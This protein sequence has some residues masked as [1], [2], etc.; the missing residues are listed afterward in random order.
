MIGVLYMANWLTGTESSDL[1]RQEL[2]DPLHSKLLIGMIFCI[3][4]IN[5]FLFSITAISNHNRI[6]LFTDLTCIILGSA[7]LALVLTGKMSPLVARY[8]SLFLLGG[9]FLFLTASGGREATGYIWSF[10]YPL[11]ALFLLG[12]KQGTIATLLFFASVLLLFLLPPGYLPMM[13]VYSTTLK[14][15]FVDSFIALSIIALLIEH[16][17][18]NA[19]EKLRAQNM[20]LLR[21]LDEVQNS[22]RRV[23]TL[24]SSALTLINLSNSNKIYEYVGTN[25]LTLVPQS[26]ILVFE[27]QDLTMTIKG[28][29]GID[30]SLLSR[31]T[32]LLGYNPVGKSFTTNFSMH[33]ELCEGKLIHHEKG[34]TSLASPTVP[35]KITTTI[36][37]L[38]GISGSYSIGFCYNQHL[39]G[40]I[41]IFTRKGNDIINPEFIE[42]YII[43]ASAILQRQYVEE[44]LVDQNRFLESLIAALPNPVLYTDKQSR[45]LGCNSSFETMMGIR[46]ELL[47]GK[48]NESIWPE[49]LRPIFEEM[50]QRLINEGTSQRTEVVLPYANGCSGNFIIKQSYFQRSNGSMGGTILSFLDISDQV[51]ARDAAETA[52]RL[53]SQFLANISHEIRTP[54]NGI[55]GMSDLLLLTRLNEEQRSYTGSVQ[56]CANALLTL[57]N[58]ILDL[59]KIEAQKTKLEQIDFALADIIA[60][61]SSINSYQLSQKSLSFSVNV[62]PEIP[63]ILR[64][65]PGRLRQILLNLVGNA[66]KF[67][68]SGSVTLTVEVESSDEHHLALTFTI[69]DTGIGIPETMIEQ[70]FEPFSQVD[71]SETRRYG[72]TGLGLSI[73]RRLSRMMGGDI[74]VE[75]TP[76]KGSIF[77]VRLQFDQVVGSTGYSAAAENRQNPS[78]PKPYRLRRILLMEDNPMNR[79]VVTSMLEKIGHSVVTA[80]NGRIGIEALKKAEFDIVLLD[81]HMPVLDG[82]QTAAAIR[83]GEA[84]SA[85]KEIPLIALT[86]TALQQDLDKCATSGINGYLIKPF[87]FNDLQRCIDNY[88]AAPLHLPITVNMSIP[89]P[90]FDLDAALNFMDHDEEIV[91]Q[92]IEVFIEQAPVYLEQIS[93]KAQ[94]G[95][96]TAVNQTAHTLKSSALT[97]GATALGMTAARLEVISSL[98]RDTRSLLD[99]LQDDYK[100]FLSQVVE[101]FPDKAAS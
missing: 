33:E 95:S 48:T 58:D 35:E 86:A 96:L 47:T 80:E 94:D 49:E 39:F 12:I 51:A 23:S 76:G 22:E 17:R 55:I 20:V 42:T 24:N 30:Q 70:L 5:G 77:S 1:S 52:N 43:Q 90:Y 63:S 10:S 92:A 67:T 25:L 26:I 2:P 11:C 28:L 62:S 54:L 100:N 13:P 82:Y 75:S 74:A 97:V 83:S 6:D 7:N 8:T 66:I 21:A 37:R 36:A 40:G 38:T 69:S 18:S 4:I 61:V 14:I 68:E 73:S 72:G 27:S 32:S 29:F 85:T 93:R 45:I 84:G 60:G 99:Q 88:A 89:P 46:R 59:S 16:S 101:H 87:H 57:L 65:D 34:F 79:M 78:L 81:L 56:A 50:E 98:D 91:C 9:I 44:S 53:K 31:A 64:G 3:V 71:T 19:R 15:R 41:F